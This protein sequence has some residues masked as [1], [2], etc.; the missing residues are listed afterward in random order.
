MFT[1]KEKNKLRADLN[2]IV[3][4]AT[5]TRKKQTSFVKNHFRK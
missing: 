4:V 1:E 3:C 2:T 5:R